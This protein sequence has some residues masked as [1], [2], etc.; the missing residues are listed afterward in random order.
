MTCGGDSHGFVRAAVFT[1]AHWPR[2]WRPWSPWPSPARP[3]PP[4][5]PVWAARMRA[6]ELLLVTGKFLDDA[7]EPTWAEEFPPAL[8]GLK[9]VRREFG[10][11]VSLLGWPAP[12]AQFG[13]DEIPQA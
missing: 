3:G 10:N 8:C 7:P 6:P 2:A 11:F 4:G 12:P 1:A 9:A 13:L 5:A